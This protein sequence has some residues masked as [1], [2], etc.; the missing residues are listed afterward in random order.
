MS[1]VWWL[2]LVVIANLLVWLMCIYL[3]LTMPSLNGGAEHGL[4]KQE[5]SSPDSGKDKG[6]RKVTTFPDKVEGS[7]DGDAAGQK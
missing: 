3:W 4:R 1:F 6:D 5:K 7:E 2:R